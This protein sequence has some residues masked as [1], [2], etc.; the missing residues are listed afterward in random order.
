MQVV[1]F[2]YV[3]KLHVCMLNYYHLICVLLFQVIN[4]SFTNGSLTV[5]EEEG[6]LTVELTLTK[7]SPCCLQVVVGLQ[8]VSAVGGKQCMYL[9]Y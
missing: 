5:G 1:L 6:S 3:H 8:N 9:L 2:A 7:P 4:V